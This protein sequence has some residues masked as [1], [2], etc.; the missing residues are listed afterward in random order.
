M[1][2]PV[3]SVGHPIGSNGSIDRALLK[4]H[5]RQAR[6]K[7]E[8]DFLAREMDARMRENLDYIRLAPQRI[9]ALACAADLNA[10]YPAAHCLRMGSKAADA[11]AAAE[12]LPLPAESVDLVWANHFEFWRHDLPQTLREALR[13]LRSGGLL[14]LST[15]GPDTLKD[16]RAGLDMP[17]MP[18]PCIGLRALGDLLLRAG[19]A[20]PVTHA[21]GV[22][23]AYAGWGRCL[24]TC[25]P[26]RPN[27][28]FP[29]VVRA[30]TACAGKTCWRTTNAAAPDARTENSPPV[31]KFS[32]PTPGSP[33]G[34]QRAPLARK[35]SSRST[36]PAPHKPVRARAEQRFCFLRLRRIHRKTNSGLKPRP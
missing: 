7:G 1:N 21:E 19:F 15:F 36:S 4:R 2:I 32:T 31:P 5:L 30:R 3:N 35:R 25:A 24:P 6:Q 29:P 18:P 11:V 27:C 26:F 20:D 17:E 33:C 23:F 13:V 9:L 34:R 28:S 16:L 22:T 10:H 12:C 8:G 14:M